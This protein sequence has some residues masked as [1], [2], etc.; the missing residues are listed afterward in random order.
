MKSLEGK[1]AIVTGAA[2]GIGKG[3]ALA[4]AKAG[5]AVGLV[6]VNRRRSRCLSITPIPAT[7]HLT[8]VAR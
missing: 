4:L 8:L 3:V 5:A 1:V 7:H 2:Q 6:D